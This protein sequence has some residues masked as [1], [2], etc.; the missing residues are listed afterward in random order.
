MINH[1]ILHEIKKGKG[2]K[3]AL[4]TPST[5]E[6][7]SDET[8]ISLVAELHDAIS[9]SPKKV[10]GIFSDSIT[11]YFKKEFDAFIK[12]EIDNLLENTI[13]LIGGTTEYTLFTLLNQET[14]STGGHILLIDYTKDGSRYYIVAMVNN[15][16]GR[17]LDIINGIPKLRNT[18]QIDFK[19]LDMACRI[20]VD[21]YSNY[22]SE[23]NYLCFISSRDS[24]SNYFINFI[25]CKRFNQNRDNS[26]KIVDAINKMTANEA[27]KDK[28]RKQ[29]YQ[30]CESCY[31]NKSAIDLYAM[32]SYMYGEDNRDK[33]ID[34]IEANGIEIDHTFSISR[35]EMK[36]LISFKFAGD[37][38]EGLSFDRIHIGK[39]ILFNTDNNEVILRNVKSLIERLK[40]ETE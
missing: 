10:Y 40:N 17:S 35:P 1:F 6:V 15:K 29:A 9:K 19:E 26:K 21:K 14:L 5:Q 24:I 16:S 30:Y 33:V 12:N 23:S 20:D 7:E 31:S 25:G 38:I 4:F 27:D 18:D 8:A 13:S 28:V 39:D 34:F 2:K 36:R 22:S 37:W 11:S 32:S 3:D